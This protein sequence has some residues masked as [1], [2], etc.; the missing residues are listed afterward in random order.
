MISAPHK[1]AG[2]TTISLGILHN[3]VEEGLSVQSFK[4][5][6]DYIDPM[7]L[8]QASG[9]DCHNLDPYLL[10]QTGCLDSFV[11]HGSD[12]EMV[13]IEGNH[14]LHD[15]LSLDGSDSSSGLANLLQT[16]VLLVLDSRG[17]NR[18]AAAIVT[19]MQKMFPEPKIAGV[20]LNFVR[21]SRQ[22]EKQRAAIEKYCGVPV[23][24]AI[25]VDE[26]VTIPERHLGLTTVEETENARKIICHAGELVA[27]YCEMDA[28]CSLFEN[29]P[30]LET[31]TKN[32]LTASQSAT[33]KIGVFHDSAFCFYYPE[34][35]DA[36]RN[37]GAELVFIDALHE[38]SLPNLDGLYI[39]GGFPESFF[40]ELSANRNL[41]AEVKE[42]VRSGLPLYAEC[43]GLIYL[44]ETAHYK[45]KKYSMAGVLPF[46]IGYQKKPVGYGYLSLESRCRSKWF[47]DGALVR[48]HEFHYSKPI[49]QLGAKVTDGRYQFNVV[50]GF[51]IDGRQD[52]FLQNNLFASF[53]HLHASA[54]PQWAQGFIGL[55]TEYQS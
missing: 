30:A 4:K 51:G 28:V 25:P 10:G 42:H 49:P 12:A 8:K 21:S 9:H 38:D 50:R 24:G 40:E 23:L 19:G 43:G 39:G 7:W 45:D 5:G 37:Q 32:N 52:G 47:D 15:G 18:G 2:K 35:L 1:S 27:N 54:N 11:S 14:G 17:M 55:A 20:I 36:L 44:C 34:N 33:V 31:S 48:A 16:P 13:L 53:A 26:A 41:L 22:E 6:P 3:L 46:E 29:S